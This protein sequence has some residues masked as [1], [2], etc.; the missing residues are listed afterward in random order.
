MRRSE[1]D[2]AGS[3]ESQE[4]S[5]TELPCPKVCPL[6]YA[7]VCVE[8]INHDYH[9]FDDE[10][11]VRKCACD[12]GFVY[13]FVPREMCK[14]PMSPCPLQPKSSRRLDVEE[15]AEIEDSSSSE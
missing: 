10:C 9:L 4:M 15:D 11:E 13:K 5:S 12:T 14:G 8:D 6:T 7:P 2:G 3:S 1:D